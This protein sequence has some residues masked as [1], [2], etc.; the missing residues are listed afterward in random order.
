MRLGDHHTDK[1]FGVLLGDCAGDRHRG[2]GA[3][4]RERCQHD[5]LAALAHAQDAFA[6]RLI[7]SQRR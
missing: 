5:N 6:H 7:Q 2:H 4:Q 3:S 1:R